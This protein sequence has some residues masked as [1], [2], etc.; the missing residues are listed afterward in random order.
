MTSKNCRDQVARQLALDGGWLSITNLLHSHLAAPPIKFIT[1]DSV[2]LF[3]GVRDV[4]FRCHFTTS[5]SL[6]RHVF[7]KNG[8]SGL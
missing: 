8:S 3:F 4:R 5:V 2:A 6:G 7:V 1:K